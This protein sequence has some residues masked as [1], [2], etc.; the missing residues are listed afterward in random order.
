MA[1]DKKIKRPRR[2]INVPKDCYFCKEQ[3]TPWFSDVEILRRFLTERG[4][5]IGRDRSGL[6]S[7]H[8]RRL[9]LAIK[10]SRHLGLL[11]FVE[12]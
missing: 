9:T 2:K 4:K 3:K 7:K 8:Q 12:R 5:I 1:L 11:P 10:Y 6:C